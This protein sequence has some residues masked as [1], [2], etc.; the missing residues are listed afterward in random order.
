MVLVELFHVYVEL[1]FR[2][3][4]YILVLDL[5]LTWV[6]FEVSHDQKDHESPVIEKQVQGA[7]KQERYV[8][9]LETVRQ[10]QVEMNERGLVI[11]KGE[12]QVEENVVVRKGAKGV[13]KGVKDVVKREVEK[14]VGEM[15]LEILE[16][17]DF[18]ENE[19][20]KEESKEQHIEDESQE[21]KS[22]EHHSLEFVLLVLNTDLTL[23]EREVEQASNEPV[24]YDSVSIPVLLI[25]FDSLLE[26][27]A[28]AAINKKEF[29]N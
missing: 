19:V 21:R 7:V 29:T 16:I 27:L 4:V 25:S 8:L 11:L 15:T 12:S 17:Q 9:L 22:F 20:K 13:Q 5:I 1:E 6:L 24:A 23:L 14:K 3:V 18:L 28:F 2:Q 26:L 10:I